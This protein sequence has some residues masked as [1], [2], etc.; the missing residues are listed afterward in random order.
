MW[1]EAKKN[2]VDKLTI[3]QIDREVRAVR[4]QRDKKQATKRT[5][6]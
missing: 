6:K 2:G 1:E 3:A 4:R 5:R